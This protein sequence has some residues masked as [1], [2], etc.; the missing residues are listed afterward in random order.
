MKL[1]SILTHI[2]TLKYIIVVFLIQCLTSKFTRQSTN[3]IFHLLSFL[4]KWCF[5]R[6]CICMS[7]S[8][9]CAFLIVIFLLLRDSY[10]LNTQVIWVWNWQFIQQ[11]SYNSKIFQTNL[12]IHNNEITLQLLRRI[13]SLNWDEKLDYKILAYKASVIVENDY[14]I[15]DRHMEFVWVL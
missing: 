5:L 15:I 10:T 3:W 6:S 11:L 2:W 4:S 14:P 12:Q 9:F 1:G 8:E 7:I 13:F